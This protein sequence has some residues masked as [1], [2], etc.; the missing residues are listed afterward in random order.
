[1][2]VS[3]ADARASSV[4]ATT[5]AARQGRRIRV[6]YILD[7]LDVGGTELNAVR[8]AERVDREHFDLVGVTFRAD[9]PLAERYSR[10]GVPLL[11]AP[12]RSLRSPSTARLSLRLA[13][14]LRAQ[15][16]DV[17]HCHDFYTNLV[18]SAAAHL[19]RCTAVIV[20]RR[21]WYSHP[22]RSLRL[23]NRVT[24]RLADCVLANSATIAGELVRREGIRADRVATI[25]NFVDEDAFCAPPSEFLAARRT[26][27]SVPVDATV[28]GVVSRLVPVKDL[29]SLVEAVARLGERWPRLHL[30]LVGDGECRG[31]LGSQAVRLGIGDR[32]HFAGLHSGG[33]NAH[34]LFDISASTS[35]SEGFPNT[36]VEAMAAGRAIVATAVGG[37]V[38]A[39]RDGVDG[40]LVPPRRT[41]AV[42]DALEAMLIAPARRRAL[43]EAA[44]SRARSLFH[45]SVVLP[46]VEELYRRLAGERRR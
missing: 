7:N 5:G 10:A 21:W 42:V 16:V 33:W 32:V 13:G 4:D 39:V 9:G 23:A 36:I 14:W 40:Q 20:S 45:A 44:R 41:D 15:R 6:A 27:F 35:L 28:V 11:H 46:Q 29:G 19:A 2:P 34:H 31:A 8:T 43:G 24:D 30:L 22:K 17:V 3:L 18:G 38:D 25:P 37:T 12:L 26:A 1:M